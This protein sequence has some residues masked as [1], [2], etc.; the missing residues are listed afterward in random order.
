[1]KNSL[2]V[3]ALMIMIGLFASCDTSEETGVQDV[4][5]PLALTLT[6]APPS[7]SNPEPTTLQAAAVEDTDAPSVGGGNYIG[8]LQVSDIIRFGSHDWRVLE[9]YGNDTA[10]IITE[11]IVMRGEFHNFGELIIT[12]EESDLRSYLIAIPFYSSL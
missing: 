7:A 2:L 6:S 5:D 9:V 10:L 12:W 4:F 8:E 11:N 3:L 1:M